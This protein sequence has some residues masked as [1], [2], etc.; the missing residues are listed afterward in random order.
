MTMNIRDARELAASQYAHA[1]AQL[2]GNPDYERLRARAEA[3]HNDGGS[4]YFARNQ[5]ALFLE[6][7][8]PMTASNG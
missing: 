3:E 1:H 5:F 4:S 8:T 2:S 7:H 6:V